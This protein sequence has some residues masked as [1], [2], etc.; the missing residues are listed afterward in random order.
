VRIKWYGSEAGPN[1]RRPEA[2]GLV[3]NRPWMIYQRAVIVKGMQ[4]SRAI[5]NAPRAAPFG[6]PQ[7]GRIGSDPQLETG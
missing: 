6:Y 3:L 4:K 5:L 2:E 1:E 7:V